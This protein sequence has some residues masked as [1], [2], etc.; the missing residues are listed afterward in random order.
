MAGNDRPPPLSLASSS[1]FSQIR[2]KRRSPVNMATSGEPVNVLQIRD[3][4]TPDHFI[5]Y[6][7]THHPASHHPSGLGET[8][9]NLCDW[10]PQASC[11]LCRSDKLYNNHGVSNG[12]PVYFLPRILWAK[13]GSRSLLVE[14]PK[15]YG[16]TF[17]Y[18]SAACA[19]VRSPAA[20]L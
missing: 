1:F 8:L 17:N 20:R 13:T 3:L 12:D 10:C 14:A 18:T 15:P 16:Y 6:T 9:G 4:A 5:Y 7:A 2:G 19:G 11:Q